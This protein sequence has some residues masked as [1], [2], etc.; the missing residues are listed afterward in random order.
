ML[1]TMINDRIIKILFL[2]LAIGIVIISEFYRPEPVKPYDFDS[3]QPNGAKGFYY[4]LEEL[5][6]VSE[7]VN[8]LDQTEGVGIWIAP[9]ENLVSNRAP[10]F[11]DW[12]RSGHAL[13]IFGNPYIEH[14]QDDELTD[15]Y[16]RHVGKN[17]KSE[18][19]YVDLPLGNG[20][21]R[22]VADEKICTNQVLRKDDN[23]VKISALL[24]EF[25][26]E[27]ILLIDASF[28]PL[29][30]NRESFW[31]TIPAA[32][33]LIGLQLLAGIYFFL[34]ARNR[35]VGQSIAEFEKES[36][37]Q[38][39]ESILALGRLIHKERHN[40]ESLQLIYK[41]F[42]AEI[43]LYLGISE[44]DEQHRFS[45]QMKIL[46]PAMAKDLD[47]IHYTLGKDT[48]YEKD[49][50][51]ATQLMGKFSERWKTFEH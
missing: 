44:T 26:D 42:R 47:F 46:Y 4:L 33:W 21:L 10:D 49:L 20:I 29:M 36:V 3:V 16:N 45:E 41:Q 15:A 39:D 51:Q 8:S 7:V 30:E 31:G 11:A 24:R 27:R 38:E 18:L 5:G 40:L 1:K 23:A 9:S 2:L 12:V 43:A 48:V 50:L 32:G 25:H 37:P 28:D 14:W 17:V 22:L 13:L 35:Y 6:F 34:S 19:E